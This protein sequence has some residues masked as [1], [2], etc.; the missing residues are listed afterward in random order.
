MTGLTERELS[1]LRAIGKA[2]DEHEDLGT[3]ILLASLSHMVA[4]KMLKGGLNKQQALY[5]F[6]SVFD[7]V[8][9]LHKLMSREVADA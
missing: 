4:A 2:M 1:F 8:V 5:V 7:H 9:S 6:S 3:H